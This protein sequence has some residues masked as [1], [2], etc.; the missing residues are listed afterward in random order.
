MTQ[1]KTSI[2]DLNNVNHLF[3]DA[4]K[5]DEFVNNIKEILSGLMGHTSNPVAIR[6]KQSDVR[7]LVEVLRTEKRFLEA[8]QKYNQDHPKFEEAKVQ[9]E[10][11]IKNFENLI[12]I[13]WPLR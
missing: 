6:G 11:Q 1:S 2:L 9:N 7:A 5:I 8:H 13:E 10:Q 4:S 3:E 12:G